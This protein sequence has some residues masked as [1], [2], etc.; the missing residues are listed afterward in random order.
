[1]S[2]GNLNTFKLTQMYIVFDNAKSGFGYL[3]MR[4]ASCLYDDLFYFKR[5]SPDSGLIT[6]CFGSHSLPKLLFFSLKQRQLCLFTA[7]NPR[8]IMA[9]C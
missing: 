3:F 9:V 8:T 4:A 1:M 2:S 7:T 5:M 6:L